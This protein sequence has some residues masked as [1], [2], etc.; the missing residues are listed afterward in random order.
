MRHSA[1]ALTTALLTVLP[2]GPAT[3]Q[4]ATAVTLRPPLGTGP[5]VARAAATWSFDPC[6]RLRASGAARQVRASARVL[7]AL[8]SGYRSS[9]VTVSECARA[10]SGRFVRL[11]STSGRVGSAGFAAPGEK[12]EGDRRSPTGV[13]PVGVGFGRADPGSGLGYLRL[14]PDQC[15]GSRV[16]S[17]WYNRPFR[18]RCVPPDERMYSYVRGAYRQGIVI[19]YNMDPIGQRAGSAI[20]LHVRTSGATAG[21]LATDEETVVRVMRRFRPGDTVVMG[22]REAWFR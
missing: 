15:W 6:R 12:R 4:E 3:A 18:G 19:R 5:A 14:R 11:A 8:S 20:F 1:A 7:V 22:P 16:G 9:W 17:K 2:G 21:C 13:F 10:R